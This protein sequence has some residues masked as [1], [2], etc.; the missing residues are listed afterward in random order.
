M[1]FRGSALTG[2]TQNVAVIRAEEAATVTAHKR[3]IPTASQSWYGE[4]DLYKATVRIVHGSL[5]DTLNK[6]A[7]WPCRKLRKALN[8]G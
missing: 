2:K 6:K 5:A 1:Q 7:D 3:N 4:Q 8:G